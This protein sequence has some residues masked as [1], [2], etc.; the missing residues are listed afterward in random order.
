MSTRHLRSTRRPSA[1]TPPYTDSDSASDSDNNGASGDSGDSEWNPQSKSV[2]SDGEEFE[3]EVISRSLS[4]INNNVGEAE[5]SE[6]EADVD[7]NEED[8]TDIDSSNSESES[9]SRVPKFKPIK[10]NKRPFTQNPRSRIS[11]F[12]ETAP[13]DTPSPIDVFRLFFTDNEL[14]LFRKGD[15]EEQWSHDFQR[16]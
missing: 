5:Y 8:E 14:G 7:V 9:E 11:E 6:D 3:V 2:D 13:G 1:S 10:H 16:P 15:L 4:R 12:V